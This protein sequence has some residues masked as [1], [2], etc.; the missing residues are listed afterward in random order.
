MDPESPPARHR[1]DRRAFSFALVLGLGIATI[2]LVSREHNRRTTADHDVSEANIARRE[3]LLRKQQDANRSSE[4][5]G[6]R[7]TEYRSAL[8]RIAP[9]GIPFGQSKGLLPLPVAGRPILL[10]GERRS[11]EAPPSTALVLRT[12]GDALV[13]SFADG[14][15]RDIK[16]FATG[17]KSITIDA[18]GGYTVRLSGLSTTTKK[19]GE[20]VLAAE[21]IGTMRA[22][23]RLTGNSDSNEELWI[24]RRGYGSAIRRRATVEY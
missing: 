24:R 18:G 13:T 14:W 6:L 1:Q 5:E 3:A 20:F 12:A 19:I 4:L 7:Q 23:N 8:A 21:P 9:P 2:G 22:S 17:K 10:F 16:P 15:L 11:P